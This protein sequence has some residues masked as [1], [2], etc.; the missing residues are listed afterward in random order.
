[1]SFHCTFLEDQSYTLEHNH[2]FIVD[3]LIHHIGGQSGFK[4]QAWLRMGRE[5]ISLKTKF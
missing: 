1:M 2:P 3:T 4:E 5:N